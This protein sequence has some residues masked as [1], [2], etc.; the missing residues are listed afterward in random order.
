MNPAT[1]STN[2][3]NSILYRKRSTTSIVFYKEYFSRLPGYP[4]YDNNSDLQL[5]IYSLIPGTGVL[6]STVLQDVVEDISAN[7][8]TAMGR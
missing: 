5:A 1:Y 3:C 4:Q 8:S 2:K 7:I 6:P